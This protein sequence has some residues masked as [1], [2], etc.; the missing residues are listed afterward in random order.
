VIHARTVSV[1]DAG[2]FTTRGLLA[3][4][5]VA[6]RSVKA[7]RVKTKQI[8]P[9]T[10]EQLGAVIDALPA[11]YRAVAVVGAGCGLR[12]GEV[13][14]LRV[15]DVDFLHKTVH[16]RQQVKPLRGKVVFAPPKGGKE[17]GVP[18]PDAVA[19]ELAEQLRRHPP[20]GELV[21]TSARGLPIENS[22]FNASVW[23][24]ALVA[25]G[26][27]PSRANGMHALRHFYA[28]VLLDAG[29]SIRALAEHL[30][31]RDPGFT[32]R[33]YAHM[34]PNSAARTRRAIDAMF[35]NLADSARTTGTKAR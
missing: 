25:A 19:F 16:V 24:P 21:F 29:E 11:K 31:H 30:G 6:S 9:W 2:Y 13:F 7:P 20:R 1:V 33:V 27:E 18:L 17:R 34:M 5:P 8:K 23:K 3:R 15:S 14:G 28:S 10:R 32:L 22:Y 35:E 12:Q 4:N 26:V